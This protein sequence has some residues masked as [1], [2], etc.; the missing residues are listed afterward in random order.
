MNTEHNYENLISLN[1]LLE[2]PVKKIDFLLVIFQLR[3]PKIRKRKVRGW[4][5]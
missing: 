2:N 4:F 3:K 1:V 5:G